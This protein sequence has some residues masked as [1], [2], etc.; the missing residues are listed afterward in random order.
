MPTR[1]KTTKSVAMG[2]QFNSEGEWGAPV[3]ATQN[4][5]QVRT[6]H[7]GFDKRGTEKGVGRQLLLAALV[8]EEL[9]KNA[10]RLVCPRTREA[11]SDKSARNSPDIDSQPVREADTN[12]AFHVQAQTHSSE[13]SKGGTRLRSAQRSDGAE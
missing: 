4:F 6:R 9:V 8:R 2:C 3:H 10:A 5:C 12:R 11:I 1:E 7:E 13:C